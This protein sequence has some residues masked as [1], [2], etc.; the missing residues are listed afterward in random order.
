M[1][2]NDEEEKRRRQTTA[3]YVNTPYGPVRNPSWS[4]EAEYMTL[5]L[6]G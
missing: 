2:Y 3:Q 1:Y 5:L 6:R 4:K